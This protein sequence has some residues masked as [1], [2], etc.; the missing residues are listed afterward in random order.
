[1]C[2]R[3]RQKIE[4]NQAG[5]PFELSVGGMQYT[6]MQRFFHLRIGPSYQFTFLS[7]FPVFPFQGASDPVSKFFSSAAEA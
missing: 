2:K 6:G 3:F 1:M 4:E 7:S 5:I